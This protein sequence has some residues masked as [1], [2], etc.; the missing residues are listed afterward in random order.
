[1]VASDPV[2][3]GFVKTLARPGGNITGFVNLESSL[4]EKWLELLKEIAPGVTRVAV[5]FN[6]KTAPYVE[7]YLQPLRAAARR[8]RV[9]PFTAPVGNDA[10]IQRVISSLERQPGSGLLVMTDSFMQ[11]HRK[12]IIATAARSKVP[13]IYYVGTMVDDGGLI[14]YGVDVIDLFRRAAPYVD[15]ILH[16]AKP[17]E[18]P[19]EQPTKFE[20]VVNAKTAKAL[21]ITVPR[22]L[23]LRAD[24]VIE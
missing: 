1:V 21:G 15:R 9:E 3:S 23:R 5:M 10:D 4:V 12:L 22:S 8:I 14:G 2:G 6:P 24:R 11:V 7:Y 19:V 18:L 13:A 17:A 20:L 16:G